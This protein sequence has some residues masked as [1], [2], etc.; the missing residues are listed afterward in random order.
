MG[1]VEN[2]AHG[3]DIGADDY[4]VKPIILK[5]PEKILKKKRFT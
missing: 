4:L 3:L 5:P 2:L 1:S